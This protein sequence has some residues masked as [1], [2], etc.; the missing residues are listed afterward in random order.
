MNPMKRCAFLMVL[1]CAAGLAQAQVHRQFPPDALRGTLQVDA[2]PE[3]RLNGKP[4][5]LAPGSRIRN[6][7]N[8]LVVPGE[9]SQRGRLTVHY[10]QEA[11]GLLKDLWILN[12]A[13][14]DNK[15]WPQTRAEAAAWRFDA[16]QQIWSKP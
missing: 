6:E 9:L 5:R 10:T 3:V 7:T 13:E 4:A 12:A 16:A 1:L 11:D 8:F 15:R 14:L 2:A